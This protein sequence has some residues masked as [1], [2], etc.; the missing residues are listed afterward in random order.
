MESLIERLE[1]LMDEFFAN[2]KYAKRILSCKGWIMERTNE[3]RS[4]ILIKRRMADGTKKFVLKFEQDINSLEDVW[5]L[6]D[7]LKNLE[8]H[9][10]R[11]TNL[12]C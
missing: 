4:I 12:N 6:G 8:H 11:I 5:Y 9:L 10:S 2:M 7:M 1:V 3:V